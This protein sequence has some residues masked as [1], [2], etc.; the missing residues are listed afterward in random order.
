MSDTH[1]EANK[2]PSVGSRK[3]DP[4]TIRFPIEHP[5]SA[6]YCAGLEA[7]RHVIGRIPLHAVLGHSRGVAWLPS[8][9]FENGRNGNV[10]I[11]CES[12]RGWGCSNFS[13]NTQPAS[14][15]EGRTAFPL[16]NKFKTIRCLKG[17]QRKPRS[18]VPNDET[19]GHR[20]DS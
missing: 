17:I 14:W 16:V 6:G 18:D 10:W 2:F 1:F 19:G 13:Q 4:K 12:N 11:P 5:Q 20:G 8:A 7:A 9:A 3:G 15:G